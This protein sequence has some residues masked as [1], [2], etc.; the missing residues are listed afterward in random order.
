[1]KGRYNKQG[2]K[3]RSQKKKEKKNVPAVSETNTKSKNTEQLGGETAAEPN[4]RTRGNE[5]YSEKLG[6]LH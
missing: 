4:F 1:M 2:E 6:R 3:V 5:H